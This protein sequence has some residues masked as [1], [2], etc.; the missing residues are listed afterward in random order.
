VPVTKQKDLSKMLML[1][2][3]LVSVKKNL[4]STLKQVLV[5]VTKDMHSM[6]KQIHSLVSTSVVMDLHSMIIQIL[7]LKLLLSDS[8]KPS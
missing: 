6:M 4:L 8:Q 5:N 2:H 1:I 3:I 7:A